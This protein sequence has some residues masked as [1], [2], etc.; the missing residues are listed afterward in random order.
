MARPLCVQLASYSPS[1]INTPTSF[2]RCGLLPRPPPSL[3]FSSSY[4]SLLYPLVILSH[5]F[6]CFDAALYFSFPFLPQLTTSFALLLPSLV[7][8]LLCPTLLQAFGSKNGGGG[9]LRSQGRQA[10]KPEPCLLLLLDLCM[11]VKRKED[12]WMCHYIWLLEVC[13]SLSGQLAIL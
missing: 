4:S 13:V 1:M 3:L 9:V 12:E 6:S 7:S 2:L 5:H 8:I 10:P 11:W